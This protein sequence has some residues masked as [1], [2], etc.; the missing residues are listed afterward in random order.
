MTTQRA[1]AQITPSLAKSASGALEH[2]PFVRVPNLARALE[3]MATAGFRIVGLDSGGDISLSRCDLSRPL[4]LRRWVRVVVTYDSDSKSLQLIQKPVTD[5]PGDRTSRRMDG[6]LVRRNPSFT[7]TITLA[8]I[9]SPESTSGPMM[10]ATPP[11]NQAR[12]H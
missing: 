1:V 8:T 2:L 6:G 3:A 10:G 4:A 7:R 12:P 11:C 9:W 5:A